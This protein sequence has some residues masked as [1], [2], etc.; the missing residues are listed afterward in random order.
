MP[1]ASRPPTSARARAAEFCRRFGLRVPILMAPM[2]GA[3][4]ASLAAT[5]AN[6]GGMGALGALM[7]APDAIPAWASEF[8]GQS[9]GSFQINLWAPDPEPVRDRAHEARVRAFLGQWGPPVPE[10]AGEVRPFDFAAQCDGLLRAAP[11][12]VSTIMGLFPESFVAELKSRGIAWFACATTLAEARAAESAGA[13]AIVAQG[14]EAGGHRGSF[15]AAAAERQSVGLIALLPRLAD[16]LSVPIV[17]TGGIADGRGVAAALALGASAVQ[18][19]T[20]L[21]RSPEAAIDE[22]WSAAL[23]DLGPEA[24]VPTRAYSGRLGR[25]VRTPYVTAWEA[26]DAPQPAPYPHQRRLVAQWRA[27]TPRT[28]DPVNFWA[29]QSAALARVAPAGEIVTT[30]WQEAQQL[31]GL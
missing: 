2:A 26:P 15:E 10:E 19:G 6:P 7:T 5:V 16:H 27:G 11:Q 20:A 17:A 31:L 8:R 22:R 28:V 24:T 1:E 23:A 4:P 3:C 25:A 13:D 29:G 12:V 30:M 18:V 14:F 21:L 9:N